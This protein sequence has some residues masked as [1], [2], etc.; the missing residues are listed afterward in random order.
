M[1]L[2]TLGKRN[3]KATPAPRPKFRG[4]EATIDA[5][6]THP[7]DIYNIYLK[8]GLERPLSELNKNQLEAV[9]EYQREL[10]QSKLGESIAVASQ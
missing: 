3:E 9:Q 6:K 7:V 1:F 8:N 10:I 5:C 4:L 2:L